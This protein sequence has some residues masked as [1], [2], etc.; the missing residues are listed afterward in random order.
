LKCNLHSFHHCQVALCKLFLY[1]LNATNYVHKVH[2]QIIRQPL[3][4]K[5]QYMLYVV[6]SSAWLCPFHFDIISVR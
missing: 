4:G 5:W 1:Q 6:N 3:P 2:L